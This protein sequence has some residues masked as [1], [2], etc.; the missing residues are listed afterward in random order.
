MAHGPLV[1]LI[2][3]IYA[4][5]TNEGNVLP[6]FALI[7][8]DM[9]MY[10]R[11]KMSTEIRVKRSVLHTS[12][13][14]VIYIVRKKTVNKKMSCNFFFR[15]NPKF[16]IKKNIPGTSYI[17][18]RISSFYRENSPEMLPLYTHRCCLQ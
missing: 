3:M 18:D 1:C 9:L 17:G 11:G 2:V 13:V 4:C 10:G 8:P 12:Y 16:S 7:F 15:E 5:S 6:C 14:K